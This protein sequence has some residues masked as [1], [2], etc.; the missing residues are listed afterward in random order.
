MAEGKCNCKL[1]KLVQLLVVPDG[2]LQVSGDDTR[3]LVVSGGVTSQLEDL[4]REVLED[5]GEVDGG[6][7]SDSL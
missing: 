4:G 1:T 6:T 5:G 3:L 7:S 2:Q